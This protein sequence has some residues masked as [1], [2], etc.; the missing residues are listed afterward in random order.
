[1]LVKIFCK[2]SHNMAEY[3]IFTVSICFR[4]T[5]FLYTTYY[6]FYS[7]LRYNVLSHDVSYNTETNNLMVWKLDET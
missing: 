6:I 1:M 3:Q 7:L 2:V 4:E 5:K